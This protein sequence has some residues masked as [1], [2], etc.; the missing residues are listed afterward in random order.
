MFKAWIIRFENERFTTVCCDMNYHYRITYSWKDS[1]QIERL[2]SSNLRTKNFPLLKMKVSICKDS[3]LN[4][5]I[6]N[7][8]DHAVSLKHSC[9]KSYFSL[10]L[11]YF[12]NNPQELDDLSRSGRGKKEKKKRRREGCFL[13]RWTRGW[14]PSNGTFSIE[15]QM[16]TRDKRRCKVSYV[17]RT[18]TTNRILATCIRVCVSDVY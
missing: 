15:V 3:I 1:K 9:L 5:R 13:A 7:L 11:K 12:S 10:W 16:E 8:R 17:R 14:S 2:K 4:H 6:F 18:S